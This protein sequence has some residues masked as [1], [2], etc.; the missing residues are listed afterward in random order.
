MRRASGGRCFVV[1]FGAIVLTWLIFRDQMTLPHD[2][3]YPLFQSLNGVRDWA[4]DN[5]SILEP[6]RT[7]IGAI[8]SFFDDLIASLGWPGVI[9][10]AGGARRCS[11][12]ACG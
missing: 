9:G 6:I 4:N 11:S 7:G 8:V 12:V 1:L 10:L 3:D 2:D 5:R